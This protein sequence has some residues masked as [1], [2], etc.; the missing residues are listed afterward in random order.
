[1]VAHA[2]AHVRAAHATEAAVM[3]AHVMVARATVH[4]VMVARATVHVR[5]AH[6]MV[7]ATAT[8]L[9]IQATH[10]M[11]VH[12]MVAHAMVQAVLVDLRRFMKAHPSMM[13]L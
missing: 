9:P 4:H 10:A 11:A 1:M 3:V 6:V 8:C 7:R 13:A 5:V 12:V 2:T